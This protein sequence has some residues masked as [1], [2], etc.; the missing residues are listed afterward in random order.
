MTE[1][2][3][4]LGLGLVVVAADLELTVVVDVAGRPVVA[5]QVDARVG[6]GFGPLVGR[7]GRDGEGHVAVP[8]QHDD[9]VDPGVPPVPL[10]GLLEMTLGGFGRRCDRALVQ[11]MLLTGA[12][13]VSSPTS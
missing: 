13:R 8:A 12:N 3:A 4:D 1:V 5:P 2:V 11:F 6:H 7:G 9:R 10:Q